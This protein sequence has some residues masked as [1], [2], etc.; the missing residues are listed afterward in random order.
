MAVATAA[1]EGDGG[2]SLWVSV[3]ATAARLAAAVSLASV[4]TLTFTLNVLLKQ[5]RW[6][7]LRCV[8]FFA[9][10]LPRAAASRFC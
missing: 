4:V 10:P 3:S 8:R 6:L 5:F 2:G 1:I 7:A 9:S